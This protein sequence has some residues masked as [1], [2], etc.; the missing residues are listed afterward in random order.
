MRHTDAKLIALYT[1][2]SVTPDIIDC[3]M[4]KE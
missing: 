4:I 1:I 2:N 3:N